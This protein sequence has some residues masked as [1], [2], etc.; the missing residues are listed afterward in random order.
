M[1]YIFKYFRWICVSGCAP[2]PKKWCGPVVT[3][4]HGRLLPQRHGTNCCQQHANQSNAQPPLDFPTEMQQAF[5]QSYM[6][7]M[8][9]TQ[10]L[11][12][13]KPFFE[14]L[15]LPWFTCS[16]FFVLSR[17]APCVSCSACSRWGWAD[18]CLGKFLLERSHTSCKDK[19]QPNLAPE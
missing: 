10:I 12:E 16:I 14:P 1:I 9:K 7:G 19:C 4:T 8:I 18:H 17:S 13:Q 6:T 5:R 3:E 15:G 11:T 2:L